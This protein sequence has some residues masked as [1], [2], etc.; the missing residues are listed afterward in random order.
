MY[1]VIGWDVETHLIE[2]GNKTPKLVCGTFSGDGSTTAMA[3]EWVEKFKDSN[4][5]IFN[6]GVGGWT[7][8]VN[9]EHV[10]DAWCFFIQEGA[11]MVAQNQPFDLG[12]I[13]NEDPDLI[14][15]VL[16]LIED[17]R[18][19]DT[20]VREKLIAIAEDNFNFDSR[21]QRNPGNFSLAYLVELYLGDRIIDDKKNPDSWRYRFKELQDLPVLEWPQAAKDYAI[22]D[23][24]YC[25]KIYQQQAVEKSLPE[26]I[27]VDSKGTV[28]NELEQTAAAFCLHLMACH[29]VHTDKEAV[30]KFEKEVSRLATEADL[31]AKNGG[32]LRINKCKTCDGTGKEAVGLSLKPCYTCNGDPLYLP[33]RCKVPLAKPSIHKGR[34]QA[35]VSA[36]YGNEPPLTNASKKF[37]L[38][39]VKTDSDTLKGSGNPELI[40]YA[41]G[42][43]YKKLLNTYLPILQSGVDRPITSS[44]NV[45]VRSGRTSW[46][47]PNFQ[48]P[49]RKGGFRECFVP[50]EGRV[51]AAIDYSSLELCTLAQ[52]N[53]HLFNFSKMAEALREGKDLHLAFGAQLLNV[54]YEEAM[55]RR[56][57]GDPEIKKARQDAKAGNFGFPGGL[58]IA[59][60]VDYASSMG[61]PMTFNRAQDLKDQWMETW[62]EMVNY[63]NMIAHASDTALGNSGRFTVRHIGSDRL[64]GGCSYTSG[65]NTYFQGLAADGAKA[66][67]WELTKAMYSDVGPLSPLYGVRCWAF[68]HDEFLF[69]GPEEN[70]HLWAQAASDIMVKEM[71]KY[72][73]D[74]PI[75]AEPALMRRWYKDAEPLYNQEGKLLIWE[76]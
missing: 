68:I 20:Q 64:R 23:A 52:V 1:L 44:P 50:R 55:E 33:K 41:E 71:Q 7:L 8:L 63:F 22:D 57:A 10:V 35:L 46:R 12:V 48:N 3:T 30:K 47:A 29:G 36:S 14:P 72:T 15:L 62:P 5:V 60:F 45:L 66:A 37:P 11:T 39:Q 73:P 65:A 51:F 76:K 31:A 27:M 13:C 59:A 19:V 16:H 17:G 56:A 4:R 21:T 42:T 9:R 24:W 58:G 69:E 40:K 67:M 43:E 61:I 74:V 53:L 70:S 49:P 54:S 34:L 18:L 32:F 28:T 6:P 38:G 75:K 26:G 25:W 2:P